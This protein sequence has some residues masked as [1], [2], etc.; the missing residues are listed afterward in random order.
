MLDLVVLAHRRGDGYEGVQVRTCNQG[1]DEVGVSRGPWS[2]GYDDFESLHNV[3]IT[4]GGLPAPEYPY[5][6]D[7]QLAPGECVKG[8]INYTSVPGERADGIQYAPAGAE[9]VRWAF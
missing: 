9:P 7:R 1:E 3:D 5:L 6:D 2:L 4:G 8:W